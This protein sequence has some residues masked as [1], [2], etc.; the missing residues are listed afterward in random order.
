MVGEILGAS[1]WME[2]VVVA[3]REPGGGEGLEAILGDL[4]EEEEEEQFLPVVTETREKGGFVGE[5]A[6]CW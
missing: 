3:C 1:R 5:S 2:E 4:E 6:V